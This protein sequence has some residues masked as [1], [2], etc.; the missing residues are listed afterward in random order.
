VLVT[1]TLVTAASV[2]AQQASAPQ[3]STEG[4]PPETLSPAGAQSLVDRALAHELS[5]VEDREHPMRYLLRKATPRLT[6]TR[7]I[8][9]TKDGDVARL[10]SVNDQPLGPEQDQSERNRLEALLA[11]PSQERH[12]KQAEDADAGRA[13]KVLR[14]LPRAFLYQDAGPAPSPAGPAERFTFRP[15]PDF[16]PPDLET[17]ILTA[18]TGELVVDRAHER[19]THLEGHL[20]HDVDF[21]WGI[22][23]RLAKGGSIAIDQADVNGDQWRTVRFAM[24]MNGRVFLKTRLFETTE[25]QSQYAPVPSGLGYSSAVQMLL[26]PAAGP[27]PQ[28]AHPGPPGAQ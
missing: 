19:V 10:V 26:E 25:Q 28:P 18:I 12:R 21:G 6:S 4:P 13:L 1:A 27:A 2:R 14:A 22:L 16:E 17:Q 15:N 5:A 9:E 20:E 3:T 7:E 23:G 8:I 11:D 24:T